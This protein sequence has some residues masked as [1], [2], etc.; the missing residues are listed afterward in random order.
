VKAPLRLRF[1]YWLLALL[2]VFL[3][4]QTIVYGFI[5]FRAWEQHPAKDCM[6]T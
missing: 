1:F 6:I 4:L 5:E 2:G 3:L